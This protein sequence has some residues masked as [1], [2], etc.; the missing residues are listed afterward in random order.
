VGDIVVSVNGNRIRTTGQYLQALDQATALGGI[1]FLVRTALVA[2]FGI[3]SL[4]VGASEAVAGDDI[5]SGD[6]SVVV[7][8]RCEWRCVPVR[9]GRVRHRRALIAKF[10]ER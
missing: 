3:S 6:C 7:G 1:K 5:V 2:V 10:I 4:A 8:Y 9:A